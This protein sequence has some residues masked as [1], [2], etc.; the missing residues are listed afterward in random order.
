MVAH[1]AQSFSSW[2][3]SGSFSVLCYD[4][5]GCYR[6]DDQVSMWTDVFSSPGENPQVWNCWFAGRCVLN[7]MR[8]C[9]VVFQSSCTILHLSALGHGPLRA[10]CPCWRAMGVVV[11]QGRSLH[12]PHAG[13]R[14]HFPRSSLSLQI[15][16]EVPGLVCSSIY[17]YWIVFF[18]IE[19]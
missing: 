5:S 19:L 12:L 10:P 13:A 2:R 8:K 14:E 4:A 7:F 3:I 11:S 18:F 17:F 16:F 9:Q 15:T 1:F 6:P